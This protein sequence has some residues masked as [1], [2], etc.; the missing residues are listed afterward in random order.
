MKQKTLKDKVSFTGIGLHTGTEGKVT[1]WPAEADSGLRLRVGGEEVRIAPSRAEGANHRTAIRVGERTIHT[2]EH[3]LAPLLGLGVDNAWI[4]VEGEEIPGLDGSAKIFAE[5]IAAT[6][7]VEQER[8]AKVLKLREAIAVGE[9]GACI[10]AMPSSDGSFRVTYILDYPESPLAQGRIEMTVTP[11]A[12]LAEI[13]PCRTFVM[14]SH[15]EKMLKAGLG[16]GANTQNTLVLDGDHVLENTLRF[17]DECARH[18]LLDVVGDLATVGQRLA[19]HVVAHKSGHDLNL[20]LARR[21]AEEALRMEH[22]RGILDIRQIEGLLPHRYPFLLVDRVLELDPPNRIVTLKNVTRNEDFF[23]GHFPGQPI[24]PGVLQIEALAQ[25]GG[26]LIMNS[27]SSK[28]KL[29][30]LMA[31][32]E[33]KFRRPVVPGDQLRMEVV[34]EKIK[35]R[36]GVANAWSTVDGEIATEVRIKFALVDADQYT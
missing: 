28:G 14:K 36:V 13:A 9:K 12:M 27:P 34:F 20:K 11:E 1:L 23:N 25:S 16:K 18:K 17:R 29:A 2:V 5:Q 32:E 15:A 31:I 10:T 6:G 22:P 8:E 33:V 3:L 7:L 19:I 4:E 24:M 30:V 35:G 21:L 26:I